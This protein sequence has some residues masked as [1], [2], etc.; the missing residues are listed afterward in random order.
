[1]K[2][3]VSVPATCANLG[4]GFDVFGAAI[5]LRNNFSVETLGRGMK[6]AFAIKGI[7]CPI[8]SDRTNLFYRAFRK[9]LNSAMPVRITIENNIPCRSGLG[10][11]ATAVTAGIICAMLIKQGRLRADDEAFRLDVAGAAIKMEG[12]PDNVA[13]ALL[14]G[15]C[16]S[17]KSGSGYGFRKICI[18]RDIMPV[19]VYPHIEKRSTKHTRKLLPQRVLMKD[20]VFNISR[21]ALL[22]FSFAGGNIQPLREAMEDRLHQDVRLRFYPHCRSAID[23]LIFLG[24]GGAAL[25]GSGPAIIAIWKGVPDMKVVEREMRN[26]FFRSGITVDVYFPGFM[27][28]G[29][30]YKIIHNH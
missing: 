19:I 29:A 2:I 8:P 23:K 24:A 25:S 16:L 3:H 21:A 4:P 5:G 14:G 20:A 6:T 30:D 7:S 1:M 17:Y 13:P 9:T 10:S 26:I 15:L 11:S 12:H 18:P 22:V 27:N 28:H